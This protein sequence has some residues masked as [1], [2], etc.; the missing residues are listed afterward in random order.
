[1]NMRGQTHLAWLSPGIRMQIWISLPSGGMW[2]GSFGTPLHFFSRGSRV[3]EVG[4]A[5]RHLTGRQ[6]K[7]SFHLSTRSSPWGARVHVFD[8]FFFYF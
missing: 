4:R 2:R 7:L 5:R 3:R 6:R 8:R 1:M